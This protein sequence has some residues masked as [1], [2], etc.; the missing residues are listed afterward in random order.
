MDEEKRAVL[1]H[2]I[3]EF[4]LFAIGLGVLFLILFM[5]NF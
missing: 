5:R 2:Y 1:I 4:I 3:T